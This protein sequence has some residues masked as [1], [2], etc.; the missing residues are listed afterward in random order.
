MR[1]SRRQMNILLGSAIGSLATGG[2]VLSLES[3]KDVGETGV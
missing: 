2:R 3:G 1:M